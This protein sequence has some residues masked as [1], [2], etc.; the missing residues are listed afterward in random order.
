M[1]RLPQRAAFSLVE[2]LCVVA[3]LGIVAS[4]VAPSLGSIS[5]SSKRTRFLTDLSG[6]FETAR[7]YAVTKNTYVWVAFNSNSADQ[8]LQAAIIASRTGLAQGYGPDDAVWAP[9]VIN[10]GKGI[11]PN[12]QIVTRL[13]S[14][15]NFQLEKGEK[16]SFAP[17]PKFTL[18]KGSAAPQQ[19]DRVVQFSPSGEAKVGPGLQAQLIFEGGASN[20]PMAKVRDRFRI[21]GP[22]GLFRMENIP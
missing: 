19:L 22:T 16:T 2:L 18:Q 3:L 8:E 6:M 20:G 13:L 1:R 17:G 10:L 12:Y 15:G 11:D 21:N 9:A 5:A 7:Q 14:L 4:L